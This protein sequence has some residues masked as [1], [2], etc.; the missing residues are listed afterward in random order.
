MRPKMHDVIVIG[1]GLGGL[2]AA[3]RLA[4][5]GKRVLVLERKALPGGTSYIF[6]RGGYTFPM[7]PL[8]FGFPSKVRSL[9]S[10]AG[11]GRDL[12]FSR[13][14]FEIR[15]PALDVVISRPLAEI[16]AEL[17]RLYPGEAPGLAEFFRTLKA[18]VAVSRDM[19]SWH[20]GFGASSPR[21]GLAAAGDI[22]VHGKRALAVGELSRTPASGV[23]DALIGDAHLKNL[24]GSMGSRPPEMSMLN[25]A[26]MWNVM[27]EEGIW[28]PAGGVHGVADLLRERLSAAGGELRLGAPVRKI[29]IKDG[30]AAGVVT[31]RGEPVLARWVVSNADYK[32]TFLD[33]LDPADVPSL[34]LRTVRDIPYTGSEFAV[35]LGLRADAADLSAMRTEHLFFRHEI[36]SGDEG[37]PEDFDGREIEI[38]LWS[39]KE[40]DFAP[41]G[42]AALLLRT[43]FAIWRIG[44]KRRREGYNVH[45]TDLAWKLVRTAERILPGLAGAVEVMEAAT[46]LTYRDWGGRFEGSIAGWSW[47]ARASPAFPGKVLVRTPVPGLLAAGAYAATELF[48]GGVPTAL[49]TGKLAADIV[50]GE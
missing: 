7:G 1:A 32:T 42:R 47:A 20:P 8:S 29:L 41:P 11:V 33:L 36:K 19:D 16:E 31:A 48:L 43:R 14:G 39:R 18:A 25:L 22:P 40:A 6:R 27:A 45:K 2:V 3:A 30:R 28:F 21:E 15:T 49:Y 12:A 5:A 17:S 50:L 13:S 24:L 34:D 9:L 35:Y 26:L 10:E 4:G 46:P 38:C 23:L 44:E 37:N